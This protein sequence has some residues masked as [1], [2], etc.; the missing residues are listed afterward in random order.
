MLVNVDY[1]PAKKV[2]RKPHAGAIKNYHFKYKFYNARL[3]IILEKDQQPKI[4]FCL[5]ASAIK[6]LAR[7]I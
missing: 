7:P 6:N 4:L 5:G 2:L 1:F 3:T